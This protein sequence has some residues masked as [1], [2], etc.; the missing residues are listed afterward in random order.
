MEFRDLSKSE[1]RAYAVML[2][3]MRFEYEEKLER[4]N[5]NLK[6]IATYGIDITDLP[7][8]GWIRIDSKDDD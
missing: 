5:D 2:E 7:K 3:C 6:D 4:I 1:Q 8:Y